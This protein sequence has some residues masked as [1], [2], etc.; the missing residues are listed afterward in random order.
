[1]L[2]ILPLLLLLPP[3]SS[4]PPSSSLPPPSSIPPSSSP[5]SYLL[6]PFVLRQ[7]SSS[8]I[9]SFLPPS[10]SFLP[11]SSLLLP[12]LL[13]PPTLLHHSSR[14]LILNEEGLSLIAIEDKKLIQTKINYQLNSNEVNDIKIFYQEIKKEGGKRREEEEG[15]WR[16]GGGEEEGVNKNDERK[17]ESRKREDEGKEDDG[18]KE[19]GKEEG[20]KR[21]KEGKEEGGKREEEEGGGGL[22]LALKFE[23]RV[24]FLM[25]GEVD[26][27]GQAM[28]GRLI[29]ILEGKKG[30]IWGKMN[31]I[32]GNFE[33][34]VERAEGG[35]EE[36][37]GG[38]KEDGKE[39][40]GGGK[41]ESTEEGEGRKE[42]A[43]GKKEGGKP[44]KEEIKEKEE[45]EGGKE[46]KG[47]GKEEGGGGKEEGRGRNEVSWTDEAKIDKYIL[48]DLS[49]DFSSTL[50]FKKKGK[51]INIKDKLL[52]FKEK[53]GLLH[54][55]LLKDYF[56]PISNSSSTPSSSSSS[57]SSPSSSSDPSSSSSSSPPSSSSSYPPSSP[58]SSSS[59]SFSSLP[60]SSFQSELKLV[61]SI[62]LGEMGI[63][64]EIIESYLLER[65]EREFYWIL[66]DRLYNE[67]IKIFLIVWLDE[68]YFEP[69]VEELEKIKLN[70]N[71]NEDG[72]V[73][74]GEGGER[75]EVGGGRREEG[76]YEY[77]K[78]LEIVDYLNGTQFMS[79]SFKDKNGVINQERIPFCF[80]D[81]SLVGGR[82]YLCNKGYL[83]RGLKQGKC[84][85]KIEECDKYFK[86]I[87]SSSSLLPPPSSLLPSSSSL[88][89]PPSS[90]FPS[91]Y[92][93]LPSNSSLFPPT[94]FLIPSFSSILLCA[95]SSSLHTPTSMYCSNFQDCFN[96]SI[97]KFCSWENEKCLV[98]F[99]EKGEKMKKMEKCKRLEICGD[100]D[101]FIGSKGEITL[102]PKIPFVGPNSFCS[103]EFAV[104]SPKSKQGEYLFYSLEIPSE[105]RNFDLKLS[106]CLFSDESQACYVYP[107]DL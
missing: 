102:N 38:G 76:Y 31:M 19:E 86:V 68:F 67:E 21:E 74:R 25:I 5:S 85:R 49:L 105:V 54:L 37:G 16:E 17:E 44:K 78:G 52:I 6:P 88:F 57:S 40:K 47:G 28:N 73:R 55:F 33:I 91:S 34:Y 90:F 18:K 95:L 70:S 96:C 103:Y 50:F 71:L 1:M 60:L 98:N 79:Y 45:G 97:Q 35:G 27:K 12:P 87:E 51:I 93:L 80:A 72:G 99:E 64:G 42:E 20:G 23:N 107:I 77:E 22:G 104:Y 32:N 58:P 10:S 2:L 92:T 11:P 29:R 63:S 30:E 59:P 56:P 66:Y 100:I 13:L 48:N 106:L 39:K 14:L 69:Y 62:I 81:E 89:P 15:W 46:E 101:K 8:L 24:E 41:D 43:G 83:S 9:L 4:I 75:R 53:G 3:S 36:E 26:R 7:S 84:E 82:C 94:S 61:R 65:R